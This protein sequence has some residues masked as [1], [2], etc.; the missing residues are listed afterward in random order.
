MDC[1]NLVLGI[2]LFFLARVARQEALPSCPSSSNIEQYRYRLLYNKQMCF[3]S[4]AKNFRDPH[5][6]AI[7]LRT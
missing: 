6:R 1:A 7:L 3:K 2:G 5:T 4:H